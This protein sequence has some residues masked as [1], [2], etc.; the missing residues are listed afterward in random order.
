VKFTI[1]KN[2]KGFIIMKRKA[3]LE[4]VID[5]II[6]IEKGEIHRDFYGHMQFHSYVCPDCGALHI[7]PDNGTYKCVD[8]GHVFNAVWNCTEYQYMTDGYGERYDLV[9]FAVND[10]TNTI[11]KS[12]GIRIPLLDGTFAISE[13]DILTKPVDVAKLYTSIPTEMSKVASYRRIVLPDFHGNKR[14]YEIVKENS[15][16]KR[17]FFDTIKK[18]FAA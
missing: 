7:V 4:K 1:F 12:F 3:E 6:R 2:L 13:S 5:H 15:C 8:C 16:V 10:S 18:I 14:F 17:N 11:Q 9:C